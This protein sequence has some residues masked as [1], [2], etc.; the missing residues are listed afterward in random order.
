[1]L[2]DG[3]RP[4]STRENSPESGQRFGRLSGVKIVSIYT[5]ARV[6]GSYWGLWRV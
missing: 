2:A 4:P 3:E 5:R 6:G 1:M